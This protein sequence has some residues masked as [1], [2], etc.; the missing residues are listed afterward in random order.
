MGC[1][2]HVVK[3]YVCEYSGSCTFNHQA[4]IVY[5][6]LTDHDVD[7]YLANEGNNYSDWEIRRGGGELDAFIAK[8]ESLR[9]DAVNKY[10]K[11]EK[12]A[13]ERRTNREIAEI[14]KEWTKYWDKRDDVIRV[15]WF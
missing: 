7:I 15:R 13:G 2:A 12:Y 8:L 4:D 9:P 14:L 11:G 1:C 5:E 10:F 3:K 6:M